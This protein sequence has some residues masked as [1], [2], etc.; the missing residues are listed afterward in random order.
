MG[1]LQSLLLS[2]VPRSPP[3]E[4]LDM[5]PSTS[6]DTIE[7]S[8]PTTVASGGPTRPTVSAA[9]LASPF[10]HASVTVHIDAAPDKV[11]A[12][13]SDVTKMGSYRPEV[14][15]AEW[16]DGA[17]GPHWGRATGAA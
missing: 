10:V 16:I 1:I 14:F 15:E 2:H 4:A 12:L 3:P 9:A 8:F 11:W 7:I 17:T 5:R 6:T 13:V